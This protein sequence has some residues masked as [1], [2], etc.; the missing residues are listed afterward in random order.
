MTMPFY[1]FEDQE[2]GELRSIAAPNESAARLSLGGIWTQ[3]ERAVA[4]TPCN[5]DGLNRLLEEAQVEE[6]E[7]HAAVLAANPMGKARF[8]TPEALAA[9]TAAQERHR[10]AQARCSEL[11]RLIGT[12]A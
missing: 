2:T 1:T 6:R 7:A 3:V 9:F 10:K 4:W 12:S 5:I 11:A 8:T